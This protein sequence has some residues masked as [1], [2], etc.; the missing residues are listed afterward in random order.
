MDRK[1][2]SA[3][4]GLLTTVAG[5]P[6]EGDDEANTLV[7]TDG[8]DVIYGYGGNDTLD[9]RA[10]ADAM[11]GGDGDDRYVVDDVS[12][13]AVEYGGEGNDTV[14]SAIS[15]T[16]GLYVENLLLTGNA[17]INGVGNAD[18]NRLTGN[19]GNNILDGGAGNDVLAGA[20]G[21]DDYYVDSGLDQV[22]EATGQGKDRVFS[23]V[24]YSL[25]GTAVE[26]LTLVGY[27]A[28][29]A[30]GN[31]LNNTLVGNDYDNVLEGGVGVDTMTGGK[32]NDTYYVDN[33][34]D[35]V[36]ELPSSGY[37]NAQGID[38]IFSSVSFDLAYAPHV[39][40]LHLVGNADIN[41]TGDN[42]N[43]ALSGNASY[44]HII[45]A[46]GA[47]ILSG[48][49]GSDLLEGGTG[50]DSY[51]WRPGATIV[52]VAGE[53]TDTV[54]VSR[55]YALPDN[56]ENL[57][58]FNAE[59]PAVD[60]IGNELNNVL[61]AGDEWDETDGLL[62]GKYGNDRLVGNL[63]FDGYVFDT[64]LSETQ[65]VDTI[66][67]FNVDKDRIY[68]S[69]AIFGQL[70]LGRLSS[71]ALVMG[72][73]ALD[74]NDRIIYDS[75]TRTLYYDA[76]GW[77]A[78][79]KVAFAKFDGLTSQ[80]ITFGFN[81]G[82]FL[83]RAIVVYEGALA[84]VQ[85]GLGGYG[86]VLNGTSGM[87]RL[88]GLDG[89]ED[90]LSGGAGD[91]FLDG[92]AGGDIMGGGPGD[93]TYIVDSGDGAGEQA[94]EGID[95]V[96]ARQTYTLQGTFV[97][98]LTLWL[99]ERPD[100]EFEE[101]SPDFRGPAINGT[102]NS[103]DNVI[104]GNGNANVLR[105]LGGNDRLIGNGG[106]DTLTGG[107]GDDIYE[108]YPSG[109]IAIVELAGEGK[110]T[111]IY[112]G[113]GYPNPVVPNLL[114]LPNVE[115]LIS[116]SGGLIR[117][118]EG[119]NVLTSLGG[120]AQL[121]GYGGNDTLRGSAPSTDDM[122]GG[123]GND[124]YYLGGSNDRVFED[125][126]ASSGIDTAY[127]DFEFDLGANVD[128][129]N[130]LL[131]GFT[132]LIAN[133]NGSD[134]VL[135]GN[136]AANTLYGRDGNDTLDG[137]KGADRMNGGAGDDSYVVDSSGDRV[138]EAN[139][140]GTDT[141]SS[142]VTFSLSGQYVENLRLT[143]AL[144]INA[145]GNTL[146]NELR[147]NG[148]A[149]R[150]DGGA[151]KDVLAGG[152]GNDRLTGGTGADRFIFDSALDASNNVDA[153]TDF[154]VGTDKIELDRS[155]FTGFSMTG[156]LAATAFGFGTAASDADDRIIYDAATGRIL[157]DA[158]GVGGAAGILFATVSIGTALTAK[159]IAV[160]G[161]PTVPPI[162]GDDAANV[163]TGSS[164]NDTIYGAGGADRLFG[165]E[166]DDVLDG[167]PGI[168]I[169]EGGQGNDR[170]YVNN[171]GDRIVEAD[172]A[173]TDSVFA[174]VS[175]TL[176]LAGRRAENLSLTG[177]N[178]I[179]GTGND[180]ANYIYGNAGA[181]RI[182]GGAGNDVL[183]GR[184]GDDTLTGGSGADRFVF[185]TDLG[186]AG[187]DM[188]TDFSTGADKLF[189]DLNAFGAFDASGALPVGAF[190]TGTAALDA[191]DRILYDQATGNVRYDADGTG[192]F[193]AIT[194]VRL[195]AGTVLAAADVTLLA[196]TALAVELIGTQSADLLLGNSAGNLVRGFIGNDVIYGFSGED[197][198]FGNEGDDTLDGGTG[199]DVLDGA[200]GSDTLAG[201]DGNDKLYGGIGADTLRGGA[202]NDILD[203][204]DGT[205]RMEGG[206]GDDAYYFTAGD[207]IVEL[208]NQGYDTVHTGTSFSAGGNSIEVIRKT[209]AN[210][211]NLRGSSGDNAIYGGSG[212]DTIY[213]EGGNDSLRGGQGRDT[214]T[215][216]AGNDKF[217]FD[218]RPNADNYDAI[219]D[220]VRGQDK[221]MLYGSVYGGLAANGPL[222]A[223]AFV[224]GTAALD[225]DDRI[226]Y[227]QGSKNLYYD[228]DGAG[229]AGQV[230]FATITNGVALTA[231]DI[232]IF[233]L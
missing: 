211:A 205:D 175:Y 170:Y 116:R 190:R 65:N 219:Q 24:N 10:G 131:T 104:T 142:S 195:N 197:Q 115:N 103:L 78:G 127:A 66:E 209:G 111:I 106:N 215:G 221:I 86:D 151:S 49:G 41:A 132:A 216:G 194:F 89:N 224:A 96:I 18:A 184:G 182:D 122:Y 137:G 118:N 105:G 126:G 40:N 166:G 178:S 109:V 192:A 16:L 35:I 22:V 161:T 91:D 229:G 74:A 228:A 38:T 46:G 143:G 193:A 188:I 23:S 88:Y 100:I 139:G 180:L 186:T 233:G 39:E 163:L 200:A 191:D 67:Y 214:L 212:R 169:M 37:P 51:Y 13:H 217:I 17:N 183:R 133:G 59:Y 61:Q 230:L 158:D 36:V 159:D 47:D 174:A 130:L 149:N 172:G 30:T 152:G 148:A 110:D 81:V 223:S 179:D 141:V 26:E 87:D 160:V 94:G 181:N 202:G 76:D 119:D 199:H 12:D 92:G 135:V 231:A 43:N 204:G 144:A 173:G 153:I 60:L 77:N 5:A 128:V 203:A 85:F 157:F 11:Y 120:A 99:P 56:V 2:L 222:L 98:N 6:I 121:F 54:Y 7:G 64:A 107:T 34:L 206:T 207:V 84:P 50:N 90:I 167:G 168:D 165:L 69:K 138:I 101:G 63:G 93:D 42:R 201:G 213:G 189:L 102:G 95:T 28:R 75:Y 210:N 68:L 32:G 208:A 155:V 176:A 185:D 114:D 44:N 196:P 14:E 134:N 150:L 123:T 29:A 140:A 226:I 177:A 232:D 198:L 1:K 164:Q 124:T 45:G 79:A 125:F 112:G 136:I 147:G 97:E 71:D 108:I 82:A 162:H 55:S 33:V 20:A 21:D 19:G 31:A 218:S 156:A 225:G 72:T 220:F 146:A 8:D 4:A 53:G 129:E 145:T 80:D 27:G 70:A 227:D 9:G 48:G 117:G 83:S 58:V 187:L 62:Y 3:A 57:I 73:A 113:Y 15:F 25:V 154:T 171:T 52:E